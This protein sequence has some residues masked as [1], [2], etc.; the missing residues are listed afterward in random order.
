[1]ART[2]ECPTTWWTELRELEEK[3]K[4][5][6][7][8]CKLIVRTGFDV[9]I[10]NAI[11]TNI[12]LRFDLNYCPHCG[13]PLKKDEQ[14][15]ESKSCCYLFRDLGLEG[16]QFEETILK[17]NGQ[18]DV[19]MHRLFMKYCF[20]CGREITRHPADDPGWTN[21]HNCISDDC[22]EC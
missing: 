9:F 1:M 2:K 20:N 16:I 12:A 5:L 6:H 13:T 19:I 4:E 17:E 18:T 10:Q 14:V 8:C 11:G 3:N 22:D 15:I 7:W 21:D